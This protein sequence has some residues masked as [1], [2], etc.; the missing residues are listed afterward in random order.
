VRRGRLILSPAPCRPSQPRSPVALLAA[1]RFGAGIPP[2]ARWHLPD[3]AS[4]PLRSP[5]TAAWIDRGG[6]TAAA[7]Y[8]GAAGRHGRDDHALPLIASDQTGLVCL[9]S[10]VPLPSR[11]ELVEPLDHRP[12]PAGRHRDPE[13]A[14]VVNSVH[15]RLPGFADVMGAA[16]DHQDLV[17]RILRLVD[18]PRSL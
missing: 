8:P 16:D 14:V 4:R 9:E 6:H 3:V 1:E 5:P 2:A 15:R 18:D 12:Q 17:C 7:G 10:T 11:L 13:F